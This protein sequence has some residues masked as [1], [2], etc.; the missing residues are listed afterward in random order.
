MSWTSRFPLSIRF[1]PGRV[2]A[3]KLRCLTKVQADTDSI[4][5]TWGAVA[6]GEFNP[7]TLEL[8][9]NFRQVGAVRFAL[10]SLKPGDRVALKAH[11]FC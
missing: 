9:L 11:G 1:A 4:A 3:R 8:S 5:A 10:T 2:G 7:A 6:I